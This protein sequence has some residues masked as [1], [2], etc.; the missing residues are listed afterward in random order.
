MTSY[1]KVRLTASGGHPMGASDADEQGKCHLSDRG[2][3]VRSR[4]L[5]ALNPHAVQVPDY[6]RIGR[7]KIANCQS[8]SG[9]FCIRESG[10][11][12]LLPAGAGR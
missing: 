1:P 7:L 4:R 12:A 2:S 6:C 11:A 10:C 5:A 8:V 9:P 3:V